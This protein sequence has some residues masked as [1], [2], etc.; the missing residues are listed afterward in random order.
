MRSPIPEKYD[1]LYLTQGTAQLIEVYV[2][3][4]E[5]NLLS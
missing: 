5:A 2:Q 1:L 3:A 4:T